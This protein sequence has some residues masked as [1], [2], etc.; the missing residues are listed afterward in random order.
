MWRLH[1]LDPALHVPGLGGWLQ[2]RRQ[3]DLTRL[4]EGLRS[5]G[6]ISVAMRSEAPRWR[7]GAD[8][9]RHGNVWTSLTWP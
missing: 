3:E 5:A 2:N 1:E 8:D 9:R 6:L 4:A 7:I